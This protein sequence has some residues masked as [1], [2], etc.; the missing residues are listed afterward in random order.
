MIKIN[1]KKGVDISKLHVQMREALP[2]MA[3]I[4]DK[5]GYSFWITSANDGK[6]MKGSKHYDDDAVDSRTWGIVAAGF[7]Y[8]IG[9]EMQEMLDLHCSGYQVVIEDDHYHVEWD[10]KNWKPQR[11]FKL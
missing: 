10:P 6:H 5:Y 2:I 7:L 9:N 8:I 4:Y 1:V 3:S 11:H